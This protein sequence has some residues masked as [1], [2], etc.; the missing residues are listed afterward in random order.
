[1]DPLQDSQRTNWSQ[2]AAD[3]AKPPQHGAVAS[4]SFRPS[5]CSSPKYSRE[6]LQKNQLAFL[7]CPLWWSR[8]RNAGGYHLTQFPRP[9]P[10]RGRPERTVIDQETNGADCL[11]LRTCI[12]K[13]NS[14]HFI[15]HPGPGAMQRRVSGW[16]IVTGDSPN[17]CCCRSTPPS[18][19]WVNVDPPQWRWKRITHS[20]MCTE[21]LLIAT[22]ATGTLGQTNTRNSSSSHIQ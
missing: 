2:W 22:A 20:C 16:H 5:I 15:L 18:L 10:R 19:R 6:S 9:K 11:C 4:S 17:T 14:V 7:C 21:R 8:Y 3:A 1:M 13:A 12:R